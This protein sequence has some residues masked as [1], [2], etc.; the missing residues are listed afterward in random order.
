MG[1]EVKYNEK[2]NRI[3]MMFRRDRIEKDGKGAVG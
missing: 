1:K 3:I 2:T